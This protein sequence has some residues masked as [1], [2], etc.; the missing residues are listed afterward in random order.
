M[1]VNS[2]ANNIRDCG[3]D[4]WEKLFNNDF[5][6]MEKYK[7]DPC[8]FTP[9]YVGKNSIKYNFQIVRRFD[10]DGSFYVRMFLESSNGEILTPKTLNNLTFVKNSDNKLINQKNNLLTYYLPLSNHKFLIVGI[11]ELDKMQ[12]MSNDTYQ[13]KIFIM[14]DIKE[15]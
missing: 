13:N 5:S 6:Y 3:K 10:E 12:Q 4:D 1:P 7:N 14:A 11:G 9:P 15:P 2:F 8:I